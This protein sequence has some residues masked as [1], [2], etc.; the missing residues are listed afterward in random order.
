MAGAGAEETEHD[1]AGYRN[2][3]RVFLEM[4]QTEIPDDPMASDASN[5]H[6]VYSTAA[7]R[8]SRRLLVDA[9]VLLNSDVA[10]EGAVVLVRGSFE[11]SILAVWLL[12]GHDRF[13]ELESDWS[14]HQR[15]ILDDVAPQL[16]ASIVDAAMARLPLRGR[17]K[18]M[19][20]LLVDAADWVA[21]VDH[22]FM[23]ALYKVGT[24]DENGAMVWSE[25]PR[26]DG[27]PFR[28]AYGVYRLLSTNHVHGL[29]S[30]R[31][32]LSDDADNNHSRFESVAM[33]ATLLATAADFRNGYTGYDWLSTRTSERAGYL[34]A[35]FRL[36]LL[37]AAISENDPSAW[38]DEYGADEDESDE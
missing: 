11:A 14:R 37:S 13:D 24:W 33:M 3:V 38:L 15:L 30:L 6:L 35:R 1:W 34:A 5:R 18:S 16:D 4:V 10:S 19:E 17:A 28:N 31:H 22:P 25:A 36:N 27:E 8:R 23:K 9:M 7:L 2:G 29:G 12:D 32:F 21:E 20:R 26:P